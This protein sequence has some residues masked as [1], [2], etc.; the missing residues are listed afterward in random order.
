MTVLTVN[1]FA[2]PDEIGPILQRSLLIAPLRQTSEGVRGQP[3][4]ASCA[5]RGAMDG[6]ERRAPI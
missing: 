3:L 5:R 1:E 2:A 4:I 6:Q